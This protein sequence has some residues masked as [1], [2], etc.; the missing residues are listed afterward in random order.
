M[1]IIAGKFRAKPLASPANNDIR[2][3]SD[4]VRESLFSIITS[5]YNSN[6]KDARVIDLFAG[7]G[8][9]GL[10]A[11]SRGAQYCLFVENSSQGI[12]LIRE[13]IKSLGLPSKSSLMRVDATKLGKAGR[14]KPFDLLFADPPYG[15]ELAQK[16][17]PLLAQ[18]GWLKSNAIVIIE[19]KAGSAP[20]QLAGFQ[21]LDQRK[22]GD[23]V[24]WFLSVPAI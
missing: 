6:L 18:G 23:T 5:N 8:A 17:I 7:S 13:N 2:P 19:D 20:P 1:R 4:R 22:I 11:L 14:I 9:L 16:A 10:E 24:I 15:Q 3:T 12:D 21:M